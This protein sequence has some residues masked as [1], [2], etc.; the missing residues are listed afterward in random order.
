MS[1]SPDDSNSRDGRVVINKNDDVINKND[2]VPKASA[3]VTID[4][5]GTKSIYQTWSRRKRA[6]IL[7]VVSISQFLNPLSSSVILPSLKVRA[8]KKMPSLA[9]MA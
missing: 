2:D 9:L 7:T 3:A 8:A 1:L 6:M 4:K 5:A